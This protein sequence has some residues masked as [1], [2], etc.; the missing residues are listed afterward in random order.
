MILSFAAKKIAHSAQFWAHDT[1]TA[2]A[3]SIR[4]P[5]TWPASGSNC[6]DLLRD[7]GNTNTTTVVLTPAGAIVVL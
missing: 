4:T 1:S 5:I 3:T 2:V 6:D 7:L